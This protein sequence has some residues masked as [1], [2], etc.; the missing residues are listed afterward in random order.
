MPTQLLTLAG[1][2]SITAEGVPVHDGDL[3]AQF[4]QAMGNVPEL[5]GLARWV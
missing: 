2:G 1:Q 3:P 4:A 5:L